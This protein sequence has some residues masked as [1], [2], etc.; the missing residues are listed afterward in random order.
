[1][2]MPPDHHKHRIATINPTTLPNNDNGHDF[3]S[4]TV[5]TVRLV[6]MPKGARS[7]CLM[8]CGI[9]QGAAE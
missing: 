3:G 5:A 6:A 4:H 1:V 8:P 2:R 9:P 7:P